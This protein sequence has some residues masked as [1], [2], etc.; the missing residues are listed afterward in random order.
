M[1]YVNCLRKMNI[2]FFYKILFLNLLLIFLY[3]IK[4]KFLFFF[5][6]LFLFDLN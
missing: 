2:K 3:N 5:L 6:K 4:K 1:K